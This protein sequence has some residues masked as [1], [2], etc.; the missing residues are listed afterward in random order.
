M[1]LLTA[2]F[3][4]GRDHDLL[5]LIADLAQGPGTQLHELRSDVDANRTWL[6]ASGEPEILSGLLSAVCAAAFDRIHLEHHAG[7]HPRLGALDSCSWTGPPDPT[8]GLAEELATCH[9]L[10]VYLPHRNDA[11]FA[12]REQGFGS[13][14]D[15]QLSP[16]FGPSHVNEQ[17]GVAAV[18]V[19]PFFLT[20]VADVAE[21]R[22]NFLKMRVRDIRQRREDGEAMF[23]GVEAIAY[24]APSDA[25]SRIVIEFSDPDNAPPDPVIEWL[26]RRAGVAGL[27]VQSVE[28]IG[29]VRRVDLL[30]TRSIPVR[31]SQIVDMI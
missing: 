12:L 20:V 30:E 25:C 2:A 26:D 5:R 22:A 4:F 7:E 10:P 21:E 14:F 19:R 9:N 11:W 27:R 13:L 29:A 17:L 8:I 1:T 31:E 18:W 28:A 3:S 24:A 23:A 16:D 15:R 6:S